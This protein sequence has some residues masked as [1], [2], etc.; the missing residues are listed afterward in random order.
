MPSLGLTPA[1]DRGADPIVAHEDHRGDRNP[2][3]HGLHIRCV[4]C[5]VAEP[6]GALL[7]AP[8]LD[9]FLVEP[10]GPQIRPRL[11]PHP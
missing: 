11:A 3:M 5:V 4:G 1:S 10:L 7:A 9:R 8:A 2:Q 6:A